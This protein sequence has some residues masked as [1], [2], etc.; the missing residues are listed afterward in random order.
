MVRPYNVTET[1]SEEIKAV[2]RVAGTPLL[3]SKTK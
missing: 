1:D 2:R 3:S